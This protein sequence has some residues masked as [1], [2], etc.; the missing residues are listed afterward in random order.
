MNP[1]RHST[2]SHRHAPPRTTTPTT[3]HHTPPRPPRTT[4]HRHT[5]RHA[6]PPHHHAPAR[7]APPH[8]TKPGTPRTR[9]ANVIQ[10]N[11]ESLRHDTDLTKVSAAGCRVVGALRTHRA[12]PPEDGPTPRIDMHACQTASARHLQAFVTRWHR[13]FTKSRTRCPGYCTSTSARNREAGRNG[14][15]LYRN[16]AQVSRPDLVL[17]HNVSDRG[18]NLERLISPKSKTES[19]EGI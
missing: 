15:R 3:N 16:I 2:A 11:A 18:L 12:Q 1:R 5:H 7:T 6:P 8:T 10:Q 19:K 14:Y 9:L 4:T 17:E 13:Q